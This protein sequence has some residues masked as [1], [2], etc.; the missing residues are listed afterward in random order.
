M[1]FSFSLSLSALVL[2]LISGSFV[3]SA[4]AN[5]YENGRWFT[6]ENT[7]YYLRV[8]EWRLIGGTCYRLQ[9]NHSVQQRNAYQ[10]TC[11]APNGRK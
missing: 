7:A 2:I 6:V 11:E 5:Y 10:G 9:S 1:K 8:D 3:P 4:S